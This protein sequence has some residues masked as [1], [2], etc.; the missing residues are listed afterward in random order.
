MTPQDHAAEKTGVVEVAGG[1]CT[2]QAA[3]ALKA[4]FEDLTGM[5]AV[6]IVPAGAELRFVSDLVSEQQLYEAA[7]VAGFHATIFRER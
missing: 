3:R 5:L 1:I 6:E 2:E 7:K 4:G